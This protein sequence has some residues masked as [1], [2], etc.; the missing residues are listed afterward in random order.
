MLISPLYNKRALNMCPFERY[1]SLT[2][3]SV[4]PK[5]ANNNKAT[6][7]YSTIG[8]EPVTLATK[9]AFTISILV[10]LNIIKEIIE[11]TI[12]IIFVFL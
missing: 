9:V 7:L 4:I 8:V 6:K 3:L 12:S 5:E 11:N 2:F 1:Y 10:K